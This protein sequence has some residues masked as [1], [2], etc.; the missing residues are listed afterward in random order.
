MG[1]H[2]KVGAL[3]KCP[4]LGTD[5]PGAKLCPSMRMTEVVASG[6]R[7]FSPFACPPTSHFLDWKRQMR[8]EQG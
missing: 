5:S 7:K 8:T 1:G 6:S 3:H 2:R 4:A